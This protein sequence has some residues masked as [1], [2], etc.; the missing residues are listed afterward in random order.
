MSPSPLAV[1]IANATMPISAAAAFSP[2]TVMVTLSSLENVP[3]AH[4]KS[5]EPPGAIVAGE[6][7][8]DPDGG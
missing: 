5:T 3:A 2:V 4:S 1:V 6:T 8:Q 7:V